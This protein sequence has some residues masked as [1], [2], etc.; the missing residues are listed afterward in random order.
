MRLRRAFEHYSDAHVYGGV[1]V[2]PCVYLAQPL[3]WQWLQGVD[4]PKVV[5]SYGMYIACC[6]AHMYTIPM[7]LLMMLHTKLS[8]QNK[9]V[10]ELR[11]SE[12]A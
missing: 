6:P 7:S 3:T 10:L 9:H 5:A 12:I 1:Y 11:V 4:V 8:E 2:L